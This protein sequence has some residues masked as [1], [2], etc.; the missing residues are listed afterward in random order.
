MGAKGIKLEFLLN[1]NGEPPHLLPKIDDVST[2]VNTDLIARPDH[3]RLPSDSIKRSAA[4]T[5]RGVLLS[6]ISPPAKRTR[7]AADGG[8][9]LTT[10][11]ASTNC[12]GRTDIVRE[13]FAFWLR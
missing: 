12:G 5:S 4:S 9:E 10:A 13:D 8:R 6:R 1:Q 2:Q 11:V 3:E 7:H